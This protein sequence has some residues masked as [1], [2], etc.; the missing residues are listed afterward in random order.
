MVDAA[1]ARLPAAGLRWRSS[2]TLKSTLVAV[3]LHLTL[4]QQA[5][6]R[7][8]EV[9][10]ALEGVALYVLRQSQLDSVLSVD[11]VCCG[12]QQINPKFNVR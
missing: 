6:K 4:E 8:R 5:K 11:W 2:A 7:V 3:C 12:L 9:L 10:L 1:A